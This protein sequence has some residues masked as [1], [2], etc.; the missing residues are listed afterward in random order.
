MW[1]QT[2]IRTSPL[3]RTEIFHL[4]EKRV[5]F[6]EQDLIVLMKRS[7][8]K[9]IR[10]KIVYLRKMSVKNWLVNSGLKKA[11]Q[12]KIYNLHKDAPEYFKKDYNMIETGKDCL[13]DMKMVVLIGRK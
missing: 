1:S 3:A 2:T 9:D 7:A 4:K 13:I 12:E 11:I 10:L 5:T 6:Y 8:F